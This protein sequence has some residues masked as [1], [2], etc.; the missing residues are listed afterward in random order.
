[1]SRTKDNK[2]QY[3]EPKD[4]DFWNGN[5]GRKFKDVYLIDQ[6]VLKQSTSCRELGLPMSPSEIGDKRSSP[7]T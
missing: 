2:A 3:Q 6:R 1:M 5:I 4:S 7:Q